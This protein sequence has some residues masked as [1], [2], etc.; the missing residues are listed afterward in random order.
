MTLLRNKPADLGEYFTASDATIEGCGVVVGRVTSRSGERRDL[1]VACTGWEGRWRSSASRLVPQVAL[2]MIGA[3]EVF[4]VSTGTGNLAFGSPEWDSYVSGNLRRGIDALRGS[5]A[6]VALSLLPCYRP[7]GRTTGAGFW[8]ERGDDS[9]TR[10]VNELLRAAA[11]AYQSQVHTVEPP[12]QFCSD[13]KISTN[14]SYRWDGVHYYKSGA[15][16]YFK[17][18]VPQLLK[19]L[20]SKG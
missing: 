1:N 17:T 18:V 11:R 7:I 19:L 15:A 10:H 20:P 8:P 5:G 13:P 14:R 4:D 3:W 2:V 6:T 16:L 12:A 9:R